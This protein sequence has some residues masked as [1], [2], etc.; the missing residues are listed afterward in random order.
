MAR[1]ARYAA[2]AVGVGRSRTLW[3]YLPWQPQRQTV[4]ELRSE[5]GMTSI[6]LPGKNKL[7]GRGRASQSIGRSGKRVGVARMGIVSDDTCSRTSHVIR[8][9]FD[10]LS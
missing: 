7:R 3:M 8:P 4:A 1:A 6:A 5:G 2:R 9:R 10:A